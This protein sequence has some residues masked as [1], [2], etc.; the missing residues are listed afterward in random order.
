MAINGPAIGSN[1][2]PLTYSDI[3]EIRAV[4][5]V[6][7]A[8]QLLAQGWVLITVSPITSLGTMNEDVATSEGNQKP[9]DPKESMRYV[10]RSVG[11]VLG[12]PRVSNG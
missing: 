9:V 8:N 11:Y 7:E 10:R 1:A 4:T 3:G 6:K 2:T 5:R 12:L